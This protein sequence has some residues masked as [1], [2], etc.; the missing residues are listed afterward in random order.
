M[1]GIVDHRP[2]RARAGLAGAA[3]FVRFGAVAVCPDW[4][5]TLSAPALLI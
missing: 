4:L 2:R 3:V 5:G 1:L